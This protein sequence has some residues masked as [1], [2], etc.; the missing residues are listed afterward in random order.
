MT[1]VGEIKVRITER[2]NKNQGTAT[3]EFLTSADEADEVRDV[4][5]FGR[6]TQRWTAVKANGEQPL[7]H[8]D[9]A[10]IL[11]RDAQEK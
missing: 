10:N 5:D 8:R 1:S 2:H 4:F 7:L 3:E 6:D 11:P 9:H